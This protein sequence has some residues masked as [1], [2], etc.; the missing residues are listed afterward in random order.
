MAYTQKYNKLSSTEI[1]LEF[2]KFLLEVQEP[3]LAVRLEKI[4]ENSKLPQI[5]LNQEL[6]R[7]T[8]IRVIL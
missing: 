6:N 2:Q 3:Y 7:F 8:D 4:G 1:Y 5:D